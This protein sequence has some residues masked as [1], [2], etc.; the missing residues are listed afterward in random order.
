M[1][2]WRRMHNYTYYTKDLIETYKFTLPISSFSNWNLPNAL[3]A[4]DRVTAKEGKADEHTK[5]TEEDDMVKIYFNGSTC[6][7]CMAKE[8][9]CSLAEANTR[10]S[11]EKDAIDN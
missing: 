6:F 11:S 1:D 5:H 3:D 9:G 10:I 4:L 7:N 2:H 8:R